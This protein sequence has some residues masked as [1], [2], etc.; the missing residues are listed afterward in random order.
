MPRPPNAHQPAALAPRSLARARSRWPGGPPGRA[1][2]AASRGAERPPR[3]RRHPARRC[4]RRVRPRGRDA[5]DRPPGRRRRALR[6][7]PRPQRRDPSLPREHPLRA[8]PVRPRGAGQLGLPVPGRDRHPGHPAEGARVPHGGLRERVPARLARSAWPAASTS[9]TTTSCRHGAPP[10]LPRPGAPAARRRW[11]ARAGGW[12]R[13]GPAS[14]RSA[15]STSSSRTSPTQPPEPWASRF[16]D[17]AT[18]ARWPRWM[19]LLG[20]LLG[21]PARAGTR[22]DAP[23]SCSPPTTASRWAS[24]ARPPTACSPTRAPCGCRSPVQPRTRPRARCAR[25]PSAQH[26]DVVPTV[27]DVAR[28]APRP[29][30]SAAAAS[31]RARERPTVPTYFEA[32]SGALNRGW[33]PL[34][35]VI[36]RGVKYVDLPEPELYDLHEDAAE[37]ANL[38]PRAGPPEGRGRRFWRSDRRRSGA[39]RGPETRRPASDCAASGISR[40]GGRRAPLHRG[41]RPEAPHRAGCAP[42]GGGAAVTRPATCR[43]RSPAAATSW[44]ASRDE[45]GAPAPRAAR[46][47]GRAPGRRVDALRRVVAQDAGRPGAGAPRR[48]PDPGRPAAEAAESSRPRPRPHRQLRVLVTRALALA[49]AGALEDALRRSQKRARWA[50]D[51]LDR[52]RPP[53]HGAADGGN[54]R[55]GGRSAFT[56]ALA[57]YPAS[58]APR[59]PRHDRGRGLAAPPRRARTGTRAMALDPAESEKLLALAALLARKAAGAEA[60]A[61]LELFLA[62]APPALYA[63]E[64]E[65]AG[66]WSRRVESPVRCGESPVDPP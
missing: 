43:G 11:A 64:I 4:H 48:F 36:D 25:G 49:R 41:G 63:R 57:R 38:A 7:R 51:E 15:G 23:S 65:Q 1:G 19:P 40:A 28:A 46:A 52:P 29:T 37:V 9:T 34:H 27:L 59:V 3:H 10:A 47:G 42:A 14:R 12:N 6:S 30:V 22:A 39:R 24:T 2:A 60:R 17:R 26:V 16:A 58:P 21:T 53:G 33:A 50:S 66:R 32:L 61:Y 31:S 5:L 62:T 35:G 55:R 56:E 20:P 8:L 44:P 45:R 18:P 13:A 54:P